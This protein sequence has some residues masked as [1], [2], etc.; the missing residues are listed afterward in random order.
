MRFPLDHPRIFCAMYDMFRIKS[1]GC[2][3][4]NASEFVFVGYFGKSKQK[5]MF[6]VKCNGTKLRKRTFQ[7][8]IARTYIHLQIPL[9]QN[10][11][12]Y[13]NFTSHSLIASKTKLLINLK[14]GWLLEV[15][16]CD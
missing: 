16:S 4:C 11:K 1:T 13:S 5:Q 15:D 8:I 6:Y 10:C 9:S 7:H 14:V 12:A 3:V 2:F